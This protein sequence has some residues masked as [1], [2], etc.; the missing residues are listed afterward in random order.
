MDSKPRQ[1]TPAELLDSISDLITVLESQI[2]LIGKVLAALVDAPGYHKTEKVVEPEVAT[3][4]GMISQTAG[5]S[6]QTVIKLRQPGYETR[7]CFVIARSIVEA[8]TNC[9]FIL[10]E[11]PR[12]AS[13]A[14]R[15]ARQ[16]AYRDLSRDSKIATSRIKLTGLTVPSA[17]E[18]SGLEQDLKEFSHRSGAENRN[19]TTESV[20]ERIRIAGEKFGS[21][22][23]TNLHIARFAIYRHSSEISHGTFF[24]S[25]FWAG[26]LSKQSRPKSDEDFLRIVGEWHW[27]L[28]LGTI[29]SVHAFLI[30]FDSRYGLDELSKQANTLLEGVKENPVYVD[31]TNDSRHKGR[32]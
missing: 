29:L 10:A 32:S 6:C 30:A 26:F 24:G 2:S 23:L 17:E 14:I 9:C 22:V 21:E 7:D 3:T 4:V 11:G 13:K 18:I 8:M 19:W 5:S 20:D 25:A 28:L 16:K 15:H 31:I 1:L 27:L 12:A